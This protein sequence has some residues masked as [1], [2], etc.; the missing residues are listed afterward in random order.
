MTRIPPRL[1]VRLL[2]ACLPDRAFESV[3]GDID[4]EFARGRSAA[5]YWMM[6]L[7]SSL[8]CAADLLRCGVET[9]GASLRQLRHQPWYVLTVAGTLALAVATS[10]AAL[11]VV[12]RAFVDPLPYPHAERLVSLLTMT[13]TASA[14]SVHVYRELQDSGSPFEAFAAVRPMATTL[15]D[16]DGATPAAA[17]AVTTSYFDLLGA[18]PALGTVWSSDTDAAVV[19]SWRF[20]ATALGGDPARLGRAV[21]I[22]G[23][24]RTVM[25]VMAEDFVPPYWPRNDLWLPLDLSALSNEPRGRR[26]LTV[27]ARRNANVSEAQAA[28][29]LATFTELTRREYPV[30][31]GR[32]SWAAV[33]LADEFTSTA[34]PALMGLGAGAGLLL[35]VVC[36]SIGGLAAA[37]ATSLQHHAVVRRALGASSGR[38]F[39]EQLA[40]SLWLAALGTG[41][42]LAV[43][44]GLVGLAARY[45]PEFLERMPPFALDGT[46][47][48]LGLVAG[49]TCGIVAALVPARL[50]G[51][52][53]T[54]PLLLSTRGAS[55]SRRLT[56]TRQALVTVQVALALTMLVGAGL[57][58]RTVQHLSQL[59][60]GMQTAGMTTMSVTMPGARFASQAAQR[61]FESDLL[62]RLMTIP[63]V[64]KATASVGLP[65]GAAMGASLHIE[66]R[67]VTEGL[68]EVGYTSVTPGFLDVMQLPLESGRDISD[69]DRF[70]LTGAI[71]INASMARLYWPD[72]NP[73]GARI[74]LGPGRPQPGAWMEV[75]GVVGDVR[76]S[77]LAEE[78]R[79][80]A[81]G[82]T[83]QYSWPRRTFTVL[84][85]ERPTTLVA[86]L[87]A[88]VRDVD[89]AVSVGLIQTLDDTYASQ[90]ARHRLVMTALG[91]FAIVSLVLCATGLYAVVAMTSRLRRREYAI[92]LA[93]GAPRQHVRWQVV[94]QA[95]VLTTAGIVLGLVATVAGVTTLRSLLR[96]VSA[97][98]PV[99]LAS[100]AGVIALLACGAAWWPAR[101]AGRLNPVESLKA[102]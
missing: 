96:G 65:T 50:L 59:S 21:T 31:H 85:P 56:F 32:Q 49:L 19:V 91:I 51:N 33:G 89:P 75:V 36:V 83:L 29:F 43:T 18:T 8:A 52:A 73:V 97:Q 87:R 98:D 67:P 2:R 57:L 102:D 47:F 53:S 26:Q 30:E 88:A 55:G 10:T 100:A 3:I 84:A 4:E 22:D 66:G 12:R 86:N 39:A 69:S 101:Q 7:R 48:V 45:Q 80:T 95:V 27:L 71:L 35:I 23:T 17:N 70:G 15:S 99:T 20:F 68:P 6:A 58:M 5:W 74:Y 37:R 94:R 44:P 62:A 38:L 64:I 41:A 81:Y 24:P 79:P 90:R 54:T 40:D 82:S 72:Q 34:R 78:I 42:G 76:Q 13:P 93:L 77:L 46:T 28:A 25:G 14:V 11:A 16:P 9:M 61:Q 63:G 60:P 92:R 1:A